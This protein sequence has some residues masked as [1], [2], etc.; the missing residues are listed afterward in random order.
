MLSKANPT[1]YALFVIASFLQAGFYW[2]LSIFI[3]RT[4]GINSLGEFSYALAVV[5]PLTV[6]AGLQIRS[7][8]LTASDRIKQSKWLRIVFPP[9]VYIVAILFMSFYEASALTLFIPLIILKWGE[10]WSEYC[11]ANSQLKHGLKPVIG[12]LLFRYILLFL[13][14]T[15]TFHHQASLGNLIYLVGI[16]S[17]AIAALDTKWSGVHQEKA[18]S[19]GSLKVFKTTLSLSVSALFTSLLVNIPR[20]ILKESHGAEELGAFT[21][22][23][24]YYVIPSMII[25]Y[26]CQA[27]LGQ[28]AN[29]SRNGSVMTKILTILISLS[30]IL[31]LTLNYYGN[32][33]NDLVYNQKTHWQTNTFAL[34][35]A[36]FFLGGLASFLHYLLMSRQIYNIQLKTNILSMLATLFVG[37]FIIP[38]QGIQ[39]AFLSFL[40]GILIQSFVYLVTYLKLRND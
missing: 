2:F 21:I 11:Q 29:F 20:Y 23:F 24:Y 31:F 16:V 8:I 35:S 18:L 32:E 15:Y 7:Y 33:I 38:Q 3:S 36:I 1:I 37:Y 12:S 5:T 26:C 4:Y 34:V 17:I 28:L 30:L 39:G 25:N 14:L 19:L 40:S 10:L 9:I 6:L 27:I 13:T 22:L